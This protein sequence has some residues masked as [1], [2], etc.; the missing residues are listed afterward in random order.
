MQ[1]GFG[2]AWHQKKFLSVLVAF[3]FTY[4]SDDKTSTTRYISLIF[5]IIIITLFNWFGYSS[6]LSLSWRS[7]LS[8][9]EVI[10][11]TNLL[12]SWTM[13]S[14]FCVHRSIFRLERE[15][16]SH[17]VR[18]VVSNFM[19][20]RCFVQCCMH[21]SRYF[22]LSSYI[23]ICRHFNRFT[24]WKLIQNIA[25]LRTP[26]ITSLAQQPSYVCRFE[27]CILTCSPLG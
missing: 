26:K 17:C 11:W 13:T 6:W 5:R 14:S 1:N 27:A 18:G 15:R 16:E 12:K 10:T 3:V 7:I 19:P 2:L 22:I 8:L 25:C 23:T 21:S 24:T 4:I 9:D 20:N